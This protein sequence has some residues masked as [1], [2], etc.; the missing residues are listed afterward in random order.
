MIPKIDSEIGITVFSTTFDGI[1]GKIRVTP[2]D[3][4]VS[5]KISE[6]ACPRLKTGG[7]CRPEGFERQLDRLDSRCPRYP[8]ADQSEIY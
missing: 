6:R 2:D 3:F 7:V 1:G 4:Q 5:E 8:R